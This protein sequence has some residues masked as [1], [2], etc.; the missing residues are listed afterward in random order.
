MNSISDVVEIGF[1]NGS[2][3]A[4][5]RLKGWNII[6]TELNSGLLEQ[7]RRGGFK[8][9]EAEQFG[10][11]PNDAFDPIVA[12]DV[13]EHISLDS[14]EGFLLSLREK[15][16]E[17]GVL[18]ATFPNGDSP[19]GLPYQNGDVTHV[20]TLGAGKVW[21]IARS[22]GYEVV[23]VG[24]QAQPIVRGVPGALPSSRCS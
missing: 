5:G 10:V 4:Y 21:Y 12:F 3:L 24:G 23:F 11:L 19:L 2:F 16:R 22:C 1:G 9:I 14:M 6:G 13:L 15:L 20:T 7:A 18:L 17:G 8:V